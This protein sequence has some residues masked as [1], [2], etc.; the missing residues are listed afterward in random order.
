MRSRLFIIVS[1]V[2][3]ILFLGHGFIYATAA[4]FWGSL[5]SSWAIKLALGLLSVS[6]VLASLAGWYSHTALARIFYV[7][8]AVWLGF[9]GLFLV[10]SGLC[11]MTFGAA[12]FMK[13][14][15]TRA[16]IADAFFGAAVAT[17]LYGLL[18]AA[19]VRV[20]RINVALANLPPQWRGRT[21]ALVSDLHLGHIRNARFVRRVVQKLSALQPDVVFIAGDLYDGVAADFERLAKPWQELVS[22]GAS[23][24]AWNSQPG[25]GHRMTT[26]PLGV[27]YIAGNHE[28]FYSDAEYLP[29]LLRSGIRVLNNEK[30]ELDGVQLLGIHYRDAAIPERY[31]TLLQAMNLDRSRPS[32][33]LLHAPVRL[34]VSD[35]AGV[36]L[37]LSGHTH[38][39]QFFPG[40]WVARRVWGKFNHGLQSFGKL[41]VFVTYGAG[42]WGPPMRIGTWSEVV[43]IKFE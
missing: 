37:Q 4:F 10:A 12:T 5:G 13:L 41:M 43:L 2:Q 21:A 6:F 26:P 7:L 31:Q 15:W 3:G 22:A 8:A 28:E 20:T 24:R 30:I 34:P 25:A 14:G 23:A 18:N 39:G 40:T 29:P 11:W 35:A 16:H 36:S 42:T 33:L 1:I 38:G 9:A 19:V 27:Y 32:I 17:G